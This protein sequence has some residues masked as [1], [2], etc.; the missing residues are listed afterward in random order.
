M[1]LVYEE[2]QR[3]MQAEEDKDSVLRDFDSLRSQ[4][5][6]QYIGV[7][8]GEVRYHDPDLD[9]LLATIRS[10]MQTTRGVFVSF[11]PS[12]HRTIAV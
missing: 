3:F 5:P 2:E 7:V 8:K 4:Y 12:K 10:E 11:I 9:R 6:D 1:A